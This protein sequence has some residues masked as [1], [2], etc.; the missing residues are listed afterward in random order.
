MYNVFNVKYILKVL[1]IFISFT[2]Q[3]FTLH[4]IRVKC[5]KQILPSVG[6]EPTTPCIR[7]KRLS[8]RP[9]RP[10]GRERTTPRLI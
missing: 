9:R 5:E 4:S 2:K 7:G 10:H 1:R 3:F 6:F 8:A